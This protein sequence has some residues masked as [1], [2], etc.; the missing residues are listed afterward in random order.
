MLQGPSDVDLAAADHLLTTTR[1]VRRRLDLERPVEPEV[2]LDCIRIAQ[3]APTGG[4]SQGWSFVVVTDAERRAGLAQLYRDA[5]GDLFVESQ[6]KAKHEQ[7]ARVYGAAQYL[8]DVLD[9]VPV[10]I[11]PCLKG[12]VEGAPTG[13]V[14]GFYGSILPAVWSLQLALRARGLG[15][16][17]TTMHLYREAEAAALLGIP[18]DVT[19]VALLPVA[20]YTGDTFKPADRP[21]AET[22]THWDRWGGSLPT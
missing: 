13:S 18:A 4:N 6:R 16:A 17:W 7:T 22:V 10:H 11:V 5:T 20:Y 14:A 1:A 8:A 2:V 21:P 3:Q 9:R 12:R 15:S 19:Q